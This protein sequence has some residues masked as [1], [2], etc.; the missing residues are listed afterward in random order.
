M[1]R[2]IFMMAAV[3]ILAMA[4]AKEQQPASESQNNSEKV[5]LYASVESTK[6]VVDYENPDENKQASVAFEVGDKM[7]V[8]FQT[9]AEVAEEGTLV[10]FTYEGNNA[11]GFAMF[12]AAPESIPAEFVAAKAAYPAAS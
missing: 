5:F 10:E 12:T 2:N 4:C 9:N 3:A 6:A 1:K 7:S 11:D 8:W